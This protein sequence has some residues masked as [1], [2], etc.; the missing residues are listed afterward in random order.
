MEIHIS[1]EEKIMLK[2]NLVELTN[3]MSMIIDTVENFEKYENKNVNAAESEIIIYDKDFK[4]ERKID[5]GLL[6]K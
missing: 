5:I 1:M 3:L 4:G 2:I 6:A